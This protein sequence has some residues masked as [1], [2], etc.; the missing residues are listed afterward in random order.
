VI[1]AR[2]ANGRRRDRLSGYSMVASFEP[3]EDR[4]WYYAD[5]VIV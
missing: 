3:G 2:P 4:R 5:E 1:V